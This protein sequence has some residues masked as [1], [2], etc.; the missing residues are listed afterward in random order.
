MRRYLRSRTAKR[1]LKL[2]KEIAKSSKFQE[3]L[4][5]M[6]QNYPYPDECLKER[7]IENINKLNTYTR[8]WDKFC[9]KWNVDS[10]WLRMFNKVVVNR[11]FKI[12]LRP[13]LRLITKE[14]FQKEKLN[15]EKVLPVLIKTGYIL[16]DGLFTMKSLRLGSDFKRHF[17]RYSKSQFQKIEKILTQSCKSVPYIE[18]VGP[19]TEQEYRDMEPF[20]TLH[21]YN[22]W[23]APSTRSGRKRVVDRNRTIRDE[24]KNRR[25]KHEKPDDLIDELSRRHHLSFE[26]IKHVV[27]NKKFDR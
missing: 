17:P 6:K 18:P 16:K 9:A 15:Y 19:H 24:Y 14:N 26:T 8:E 20:I 1:L 27:Q 25:K 3:E 11:P 21:S 5:R 10:G 22:A 7:S 23:G 2:S 12:L 13:E 4:C